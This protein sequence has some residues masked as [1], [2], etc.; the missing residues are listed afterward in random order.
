MVQYRFQHLIDATGAFLTL[1]EKRLVGS[2]RLVPP[3]A[4]A[5]TMSDAALA[6]IARVRG[7]LEAADG[8]AQ[9]V[10]ECVLISHPALAALTEPQAQSLGL[11]VAAPFALNIE[12]SQLITDPAFAIRCSWVDSAN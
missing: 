7:M 1:L 11:P 12:T 4:W 9:L 3:D 5:E 8:T 10:G 2:G 6:G